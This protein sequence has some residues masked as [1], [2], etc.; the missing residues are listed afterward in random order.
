MSVIVRN[1]QFAPR[2]RTHIYMP[3]LCKETYACP[4][5]LR[6]HVYL[7]MCMYV[8]IHI[9]IHVYIHIHLC[10]YIHRGFKHRDVYIDMCMYACVYTYLCL[11]SIVSLVCCRGS[12]VHIR[13]SAVWESRV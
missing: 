6:T 4:T 5:F 2:I 1:I 9:H 13:V 10:T 7:C 11:H 3:H 12:A 8:H